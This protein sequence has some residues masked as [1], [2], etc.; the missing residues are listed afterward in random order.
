MSFHACRTRL[1]SSTKPL[2]KTA[3]RVFSRRMLLLEV[4]PAC[5]APALRSV[6]TPS[7]CLTKEHVERRPLAPETIPEVVNPVAR[8][9]NPRRA[10]NNRFFQLRHRRKGIEAHCQTQANF[11][12]IKREYQR[13]YIPLNARCAILFLLNSRASQTGWV[14][15][16]ASRVV[17]AR[18]CQAALLLPREERRFAPAATSSTLDRARARTTRARDTTIA[19]VPL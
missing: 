10:G 15:G 11:R 13:D 3:R 7:R 2:R 9:I 1:R 17:R 4:P 6:R 14:A 19:R 8:V 18:G 16:R 5:R 12:D